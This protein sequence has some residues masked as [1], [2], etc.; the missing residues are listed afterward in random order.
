MIEFQN[1]TKTYDN[2]TRGAP[3]G[4][5]IKIEDG[6]FVFLVGPSGSGKIHHHQAA[7]RRS[8][9]P[10]AAAMLSTASSWKGSSERRSP[11]CGGHSASFSRTSASSRK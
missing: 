1:V 11:T 2:G 3:N 5:D 10:P 8:S 6:E 9:R 7:D 4:V